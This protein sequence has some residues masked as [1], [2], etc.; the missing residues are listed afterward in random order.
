MSLV[1]LNEILFD[2]SRGKYAV[3][4]FDVS[5]LEMIRAV[6]EEAEN[7]H[8]PVI[9]GALGPDLENSRFEYWIAMAKRAAE[10]TKI[11]V[12]VHLDHANTLEQVMRAANAGFSSVML[13]ASASPFE[14]NIRRSLEVVKAVSKQGISV[15]AELGHVGNG[16]VG[17]GEGSETCPDMLTE[18]DKVVEFVERTGVD[19]LAV[20]IGTAHGVYI[21]A[22]HLDIDRLKKIAKVSKAPLV[23]HG[24]SGTPEDQLKDAIENGISKINI[25]SEL[26]NAWNSAM[27]TELRKQQHMSVWP[28]VLR[29][30]PD[31]A[32]RAVIRKKIEL[33]GSAGKV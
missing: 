8:S 26:L 5:D 23:L 29:K 18:P 9:L 27:L 2:A 24:G 6:T 21:K 17:S 10:K 32:M 7:L 28:S 4:M 14:E 11:P 13:D 1:N 19:A 25:Y 33:F 12:C 16:W 3:G 31:A 20:S 22:P 30:T 15:E